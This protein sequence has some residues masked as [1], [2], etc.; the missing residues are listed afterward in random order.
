MTRGGCCTPTCYPPVVATDS[1]TC[2][3]S[4]PLTLRDNVLVD[5]KLFSSLITPIHSYACEVWAPFE[6]KGFNPNNLI[7][8][9]CETIALLKN[10]ITNSASI[11]LV[12]INILLICSEWR[13][14]GC[15]QSFGELSSSV[16]S[17]HQILDNNIDRSSV[18]YKS[19][20]DNYSTYLA[21]SKS[22]NWCSLMSN[23][24]V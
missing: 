8:K 6:T 7:I 17:C 22:I 3:S 1:A 23:I 14:I 10:L 21:D 18:A 24:P 19:Y 12:S 4:G 5:F 9:L 15:F 2:S 11:C 20:K 13:S 16:R